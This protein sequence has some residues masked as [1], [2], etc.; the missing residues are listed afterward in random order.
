MDVPFELRLRYIGAVQKYF[1]KKFVRLTEPI[2]KTSSLQSALYF[3]YYN[4]YNILRVAIRFR[5]R[6]RNAN[7]QKFDS[8]NGTFSGIDLKFDEMVKIYQDLTFLVNF[9]T[10]FQ[11]KLTILGKSRNL[12]SILHTLLRNFTQNLDLNF[13]SSRNF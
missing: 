1:T 11:L 6:L 2:T 8:E 4:D 7:I 10:S 5:I 12:V 13:S 9:V 3:H